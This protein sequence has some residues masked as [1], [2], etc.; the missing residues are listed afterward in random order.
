MN[1]VGKVVE[2]EPWIELTKSFK[3][4]RERERDRRRENKKQAV[5]A[6]DK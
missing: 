3:N 5:R 1:F 6:K 2:I 4:E